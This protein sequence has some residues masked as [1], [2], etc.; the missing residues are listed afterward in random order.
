MMDAAMILR[1]V[2]VKER[3]DQKFQRT[4][5][6]LSSLV[7]KEKNPV[8]IMNQLERVVAEYQKNYPNLPAALTYFRNSLESKGPSAMRFLETIARVLE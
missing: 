3:R 1:E 8:L 6:E 5:A 2:F 7:R 4:M